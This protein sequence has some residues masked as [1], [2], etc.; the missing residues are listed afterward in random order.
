MVEAFVFL[1]ALLAGGQSGATPAP[2]DLNGRMFCF[3]GGGQ[4][5]ETAA[6]TYTLTLQL[7]MTGDL[8]RAQW[9]GGR[10]LLEQTDS[11]RPVIYSAYKI[12]LDRNGKPSAPP[13]PFAISASAGR[14]AAAPPQPLESLRLKIEAGATQFPE[15]ALDQVMYSV[16]VPGGKITLA[17]HRGRDSELV[18]PPANL[19]M[20]VRAVENN[21][22]H[23]LLLQNGK[24]LGRIPFPL[25]PLRAQTEEA[26]AWAAKTAQAMSTRKACQ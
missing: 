12:E 16:A 3:A 7:K 1:A 25:V 10:P 15:M 26:L 4:L 21:R 8:T 2:R 18:L 6:G 14:F 17:E 13:R 23:L 9:A 11:F 5:N 20:L 19:N 22:R 24:E